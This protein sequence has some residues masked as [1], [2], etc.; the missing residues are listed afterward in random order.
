MTAEI[1]QVWRCQYLYKRIKKKGK[2]EKWKIV[3]L[4]RD[5]IA[6]SMSD[7]FQNSKVERIGADEKFKVNSDWY[8]FD[9]IIS[10]KDIR[11]L[12]QIFIEKYDFDRNLNYFDLEFKGVL[13]IDIYDCYFPTS[14]GY[15]ICKFKNADILIIKVEHLDKCAAEAFKKFLNI[16]NFNLLVQNV[17]DKKEYAEIYRVFKNN[18]HFPDSLL[19]KIYSSKMVRHFYSE[20]E[21]EE[22]KR[23]WSKI[24]Q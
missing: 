4:V 5:P 19:N 8:G 18:T 10:K 16:R 9:D 14:N 11:K 1:K 20:E 6:R 22:F 2:G 13:G 23:K 24:P 17:G 15:K 12:F 7:F 3:T 21:I